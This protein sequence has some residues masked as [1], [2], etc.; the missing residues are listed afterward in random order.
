MRDSATSQCRCMHPRRIRSLLSSTAWLDHRGSRVRRASCPRRRARVDAPQRAQGPLRLA[1]VE[2]LPVGGHRRPARARTDLRPRSKA[3]SVALT[4]EGARLAEQLFTELFEDGHPDSGIA[5]TGH[6]GAGRSGVERT[7]AL[8]SL[9]RSVSTSWPDR[10]GQQRLCGP[11]PHVPLS[12][13]RDN[14]TSGV[15]T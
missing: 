15:S 7:G 14:G 13:I 10:N 8:L 12:R 11:S 3:K 2:V 4:D 5:S 1:G 6:P 9:S